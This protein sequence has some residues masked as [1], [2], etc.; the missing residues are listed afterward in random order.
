M[1]WWCR[2]AEADSRE[3]KL[4]RTDLV[5]QFGPGP[6]KELISQREGKARFVQGPNS[7]LVKFKATMCATCN[8][9]RSQPL[10]QAYDQ[11]TAYLTDHERHVLS[12]R[13]V[14]LRA[15][16][17]RGWEDGRD[18]LLRYLAK[19]A[20]CRLAENSVEVPLSIREYLDGGPEPCA[21]LALEFEIRAD[22]ARLSRT[23]LAEGSMWLGDL[24]FTDFDSDGNPLVIESHY[25]NRWLRVV[26]GIGGDLAGYPWPFRTPVQSVPHGPDSP[27]AGHLDSGTSSS[28]PGSAS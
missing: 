1:C 17:G 28:G 16:Y 18:A 14:D 2:E 13:S 25:G 3:H 7:S 9:R 11:F 8:N 21:E 15:I 19:H 22:I 26:W 6:F 20:G 4:K 12:S 5:R 23:D 27:E 10:D 24:L